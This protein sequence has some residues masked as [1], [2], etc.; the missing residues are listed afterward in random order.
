[1]I[2]KS[3]LIIL[4]AVDFSV[5]EYLVIK[6]I[7]EK[8]KIHLFIASSTTL[9]CTGDTGLK[10]SADVSLYNIHETNFSA[11][12]FLGG[13]GVKNYWDNTDFQSV[14]RKFYNSKKIVAAICSAPVILARAGILKNKKATCY[15]MD[16]KEIEIQGS[17]CVD[18][19]VVVDDRIITAQN[20]ASALDFANAIINQI[21][22]TY[23]EFT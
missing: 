13:K 5:E 18:E 21:K 3:I 17:I 7:F 20:P 1:M 8:E 16:K 23:N 4:P 10:V 9:L 11:V 19:N 22:I 6:R 2:N 12:L 14:A 15:P